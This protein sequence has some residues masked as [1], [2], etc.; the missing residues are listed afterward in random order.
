MAKRSVFTIKVDLSGFDR[1]LKAIEPVVKKALV[2]SA[3][4]VERK[5]KIYAPKDTGTLA[6]SIK[7]ERVRRDSDG[8]SINISPSVKYGLKMEQPGRVLRSGR[9]PYMKPELRDS[10]RRI[11]IIMNQELGKMV[12]PAKSARGRR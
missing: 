5:G 3:I 12:K 10:I 7:H 1:T 8:W 9:R 11:N 6:R 4:A 2:R